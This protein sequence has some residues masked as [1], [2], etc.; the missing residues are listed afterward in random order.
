M[1]ADNFPWHIIFGVDGTQVDTTIVGGRVLMKGRELL[2]L[3]EEE[4]YAKARE[5]AAKV[6]RRI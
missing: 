2:T 3:D 4:I 6:W 5:L 1:T